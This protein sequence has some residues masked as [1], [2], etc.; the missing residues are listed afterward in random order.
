MQVAFFFMVIVSAASG[1]SP[2]A[3]KTRPGT[4]LQMGLFDGIFG[5]GGKAKA[6]HILIKG[7]DSDEKC[8]GLLMGIYETAL[9]GGDPK[10][11][12][13][14]EA[15]MASFAQ[16]A[17]EFSECPSAKE[18]GSLGS[19]GKG[20]MV[21]EFDDVAFNAPVGIVHGPIETQFGNH[22]ILITDRN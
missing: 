1:F 17:S 4:K 5:G 15:L 20:Q 19:F 13:P 9:D 10:Q 2:S 3:A 18:G 22:L 11:G 16:Y 14:A 21:P 8:K 6:S 7:S 12:V